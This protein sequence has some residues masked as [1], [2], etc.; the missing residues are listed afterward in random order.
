MSDH[1]EDELIPHHKEVETPEQVVPHHQYHKGE[2]EGHDPIVLQDHHHHVHID[3]NQENMPEA[4]GTT[5]TTTTTHHRHHHHP[6]P[7]HHHHDVPEPPAP[8]EEQQPM[9]E[10]HVVVAA[11]PRR[12]PPDSPDRYEDLDL[13]EH[14]DAEALAQ[15][16]VVRNNPPTTELEMALTKILGRKQALIDRITG[17][18]TKLKS[19]VRKRKQTYKRKRKED[20]APTRALSAYNMFIK[21]RFAQ[22]AKENED[23]LKSDD[24]NATLKRIPPANLVAKTG[25][26]WKELPEEIKAQYEE[27]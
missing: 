7:P 11:P 22:L 19:F 21:E 17:E 15:E 10:K 18:I 12:T 2:P 8:E 20:G 5:T 27:R 14:K 3:E 24:A 26:E 6:P 13:T 16:E 1:H 4:L 23:A 25:N 9:P